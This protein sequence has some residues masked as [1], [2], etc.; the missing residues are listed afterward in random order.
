MTRPQ[1]AVVQRSPSSSEI[2]T[3]QQNKGWSLIQAIQKESGEPGLL[4]ALQALVMNVREA[5]NEKDKKAGGGIKGVLKRVLQPFSDDD[6]EIGYTPSHEPE[7]AAWTVGA[8]IKN[9][10]QMTGLTP[11]NT[12]AIKELLSLPLSHQRTM[13]RGIIER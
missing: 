5:S 4:R 1:R 11:T 2:T 12:K 13:I 3:Q 7:G 10:E 9:L 6:D 8:L